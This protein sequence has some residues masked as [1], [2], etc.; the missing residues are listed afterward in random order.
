[1]F[2]IFNRLRLNNKELYILNKK[3]KN[4]SVLSLKKMII[5]LAGPLI[6]IIIAILL[7]YIN[8]GI[9]NE[10]KNEMILVLPV[11]I[12]CAVFLIAFGKKKMSGDASLAMISVSSLAFGYVII[13]LFSK[14]GNVIFVPPLTLYAILFSIPGKK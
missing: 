10:M 4:A 3:I 5:A 9:D 13:N 14:S 11:T 6:N 7:N 12:L 2:E 8:I 1:M